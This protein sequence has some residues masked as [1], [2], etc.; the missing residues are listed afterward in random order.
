MG[1]I[2]CSPR[3]TNHEL[4]DT[5]SFSR[6][7]S[8]LIDIKEV[9]YVSLNLQNIKLPISGYFSIYSSSE[10][11]PL[12]DNLSQSTSKEGGKAKF[13]S[14]SPW[15]IRLHDSGSRF[16]MRTKNSAGP[17]KS[18][19][20][21]KSLCRKRLFE[22]RCR[23]RGLKERQCSSLDICGR[24][25]FES[26]SRSSMMTKKKLSRRMEIAVQIKSRFRLFKSSYR[27][28]GLKE[29]RCSCSSLDLWCGRWQFESRSRC[30]I[31]TKKLSRRLEIAVQI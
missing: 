23:R 30:R 9:T 13:E 8:V 1:K 31:R 20:K 7:H 18:L 26:R 25:Q 10:A 12:C 15:R 5:P 11:R 4:R 29:R 2:I 16:R 28:R 27:W 17:R 6:R 14:K 3:A 22:S 24:R 21:S 19:F